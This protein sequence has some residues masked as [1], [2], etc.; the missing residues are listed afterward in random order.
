MRSVV[1]GFGW[2]LVA[3]GMVGNYRE[4]CGAPGWGSFIVVIFGLFV[5]VCLA[6]SAPGVSATARLLRLLLG[7]VLLL[8]GSIL[9]QAMFKE[10]IR[11]AC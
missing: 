6:V 11:F 10:S 4:A 7:V 9:I 3:L 8:P 2:V 1:A 5:L